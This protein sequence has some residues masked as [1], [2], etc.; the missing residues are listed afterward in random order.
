MPNPP[1]SVR[2]V[3]HALWDRLGDFDRGDSDAALAHLLETL[4]DLVHAENAWWL[5]AVR[6]GPPSGDDPLRNWRP[7]GIRYMH[8]SPVDRAFYEDTEE[9]VAR[10]AIDESTVANMRAAGTFRVNMLRE[11]VSPAWFETPFYKIAYEKRGIHDAVFVGCPVNDEAECIFGFHRKGQQ[12]TRFQTRDRELLAYALRGLRWFHRQLL[13]ER[14]LLV[15][16]ERLTPTERCVLRHLLTDMPER[17][18]ASAIGRAW[19]TTHNHIT[20][21]YRKFGVNSRAGLMALW[22]GRANSPARTQ[23]N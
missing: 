15:A 19:P 9:Q 16:R 18:I 14:G 23:S 4:A 8:E 10:G 1:E 6:V 13:L 7:A 5:A 22:L 11:L 21:I 17:G 12:P 2:E 3:I 20:A